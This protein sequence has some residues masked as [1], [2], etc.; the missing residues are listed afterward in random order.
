[1]ANV[2]IPQLWGGDL[3]RTLD[4]YRTLGYTVTREMTKPYTYGEVRRDGFE[5]HFGP[6]PKG[7]SAEQAYIGCLVKVD[8]AARWHAEFSAA[9]RAHYGRVPAR[10]LPRITRF[11]P[12]QT[13]FTV[14]D[15][16]GNSVIY[17]Q[18]DIPKL[19]YGGA[20][21]L[22]GLARVL[23]NARNYR[24]FKSDD[25][26]AARILETGLRRFG[27]AASPVERGHAMAM[28]AEIA[29]AAGDS[30]RVAALV[31]EIGALELD[32]DDQGVIAA[33]L[34][35]VADLRHWLSD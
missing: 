5:L 26:A 7:I 19:K 14:V 16:V 27:A 13:R 21:H 17:L 32:A 9:L 4:F 35:L 33:E 15:P 2:S 23:D 11:R 34:R 6:T 22:S 3:P 25:E 12:G 31:A 20:Q 28:L 1:M 29:A 8:D 24:E 30:D 10:G 18:H